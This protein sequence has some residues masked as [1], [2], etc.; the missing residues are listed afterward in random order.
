MKLLPLWPL[1]LID[2]L[3]SLGMII[4]GV[5]SFIKALKAHYLNPNNSRYSYLCWVTGALMA[6][7][8][9]RAGG[10]ILRHI[11]IQSAINLVSNEASQKQIR[12]SVQLAKEPLLF[13]RHGQLIKVAIVHILRNAIEACGPEDVINV[14]TGFKEGYNYV[15]IKD[16]GPG[17][18]KEILPHIFK[19]FYSTKRRRTGLGLPYVKQIIEEH[20]GKIF[21]ESTSGKGTT[22][23]IYLP[24]HLDR[25]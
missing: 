16:T 11:L 5:L 18:P 22:V 2:V 17:I 23:T 21:I 19:P 15:I 3:G 20:R 12:L 10:H 4:F 6:F 13:Q 9:F 1:C 24:V 8:I 7:A 14:K 25:H